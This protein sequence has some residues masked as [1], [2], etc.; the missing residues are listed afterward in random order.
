M[1]KTALLVS[2]AVLVAPALCQEEIEILDEKKTSTAS[3]ETEQ[4]G[5]SFDEVVYNWSRTYAEV[6][7]I[8]NQRHYKIVNPE[9]AFIQSIDAFLSSLDPHSSFLDPK[10]YKSI[11]ETTSGEFYGIGIVIDNTRQT[12][13]KF[14]TV[15]DTIPD[16]PA[17]KAG[18]K[19]FDKIIDIDGKILEGMTTDEATIKLKGERN[20]QVHIKVLRDGQ[21]D[22]L[23]FDITRDVVKEQSSLSFF[24]PDHNIY[25]VSLTTFSENSMQQLE[26]LLKKANKKKY[27]G[28]ILDLRNNSGG[29]LTSAVDIAGLFLE[30]NSLVVT[31]KDKANK[32]TASYPTTRSPIAQNDLPIFIITNNYTASAAEIL[33]A[34]LKIHSE[35]LSQK[36]G[37]KPQKKLMVFLV[38]TK[39]FGKGSVQEVIVISNNCA[40]KLT[41]V[42]YY[43]PDDTSIQGKGIEPDFGIDKNFPPPEQLSWFTKY[44]GREQ[45]L[46]NYIKIDKTE[47]SEKEDEKKKKD[48]TWVERAQEALNNDSQFRGAITLINM[49]DTAKTT[50]PEDVRTREK[51]IAFI[52]KN[53]ITNEKLT[54]IEVKG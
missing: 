18:V 45:A 23:S 37:D 47:N 21:S 33:A 46:T 16:G 30:K 26:K 3:E 51:A 44:Y 4:P 11:L 32:V 31:T 6:L 50:S 29:L 8:T 15:V 36:S 19:P 35:K 38:G 13:D 9:K 24:I 42:L 5:A 22:L 34:V 49:L 10:T 28:L 39:T 54:L 7:Q 20:T 1:K 12:K 43:L 48:K 17:D 2:L 25:Y 52:K 27:R 53:H 40:M 41:N 14:L